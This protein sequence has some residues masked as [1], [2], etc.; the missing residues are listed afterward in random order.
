V[1]GATTGTRAWKGQPSATPAV[2]QPVG[3]GWGHG[4][5]CRKPTRLEGVANGG[6]LGALCVGFMQLG[7]ALYCVIWARTKHKL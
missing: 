6:E 5:Q 1:R 7:F 2:L 4:A 3:H